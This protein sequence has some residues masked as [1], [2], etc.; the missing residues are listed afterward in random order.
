MTALLE[1]PPLV[2]DTVVWPTLVALTACL[3]SEVEK[4][5]LQ[6]CICTPLPGEV[7]AIDYVTP[8]SG[9]AWTKVVNVFPSSALPAQDARARC[10]SPLA[11][12]IEVGTAF[13]APMPSDDGEPPDLAA[14]FD[15]TRIQLAGMSA[16]LRAIKCCLGGA[17]ADMVL[18]QYVPIGPAGGA[19]GG[20]WT[21]ALAQGAVVTPHA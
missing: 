20:Y 9:M 19:V 5:G 12:Q 4:A 15:A 7:I 3:C 6:V 17:G 1:A 10:A 2:D 13:C 21:V 11:F 8:E 16:A 14:N 18:G